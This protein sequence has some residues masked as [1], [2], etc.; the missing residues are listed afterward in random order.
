MGIETATRNDTYEKYQRTSRNQSLAV[1][2]SAGEF[3]L[4]DENCELGGGFRE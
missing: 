2:A 4:S 1:A 3:I